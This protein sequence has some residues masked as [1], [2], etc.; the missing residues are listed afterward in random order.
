VVDGHQFKG[1]K[2]VKLPAGPH[3]L[4][5]GEE[6]DELILK[7]GEKKRIQAER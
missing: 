1:P 7:K 3:V 6:Q 5:D 2:K 4:G